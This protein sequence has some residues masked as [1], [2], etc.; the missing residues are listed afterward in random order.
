[1]HEPVQVSAGPTSVWD[2]PADGGAVVDG[3]VPLTGEQRAWVAGS[4]GEAAAAIAA[5]VAGGGPP[6][7]IRIEDRAVVPVDGVPHFGRSM[8]LAEARARAVA[9]AY[10]AELRTAL[11]ALRA[12]GQPVPDAA[13]IAIIATPGVEWPP[14]TTVEAPGGAVT[15]TLFDPRGVVTV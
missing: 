6:P 9:A 11:D 13:D 4:A 3:N 12:A 5:A 8:R 10:Q 1:V 7:V 14:A 2:A 15:V